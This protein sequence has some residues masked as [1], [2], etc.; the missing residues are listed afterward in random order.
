MTKDV[1]VSPDC[2]LLSA[3]YAATI[4]LKL[5][6]VWYHAFESAE[7][8]NFRTYV[9]LTGALQTCR[10]DLCNEIENEY[11]QALQEQCHEI[12]S[13]KYMSFA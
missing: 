10:I 12:L 3:F 13:R 4:G 1:A 5:S 7:T 8:V 11:V 9:K 6:K 2:Q